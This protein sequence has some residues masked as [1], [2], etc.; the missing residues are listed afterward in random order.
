[1]TLLYQQI[2]YE[3]KPNHKKDSERERP[4]EN[5]NVIGW[6]LGKFILPKRIKRFYSFR[7]SYVAMFLANEA[8]DFLI[9]ESNINQHDLCGEM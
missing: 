4:G 1:M 8:F 6:H 3:R 7:T 5:G 9:F 2:K